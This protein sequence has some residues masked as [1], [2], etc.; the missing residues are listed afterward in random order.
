MFRVKKCMPGAAVWSPE[1][2]H[3]CANFSNVSELLDANLSLEVTANLTLLCNF[4]EQLLQDGAWDAANAPSGFLPL[5]NSSSN[6][7]NSTSGGSAASSPRAV[8]EILSALQEQT[9]AMLPAPGPPPRSS[10]VCWELH[11]ENQTVILKSP[12][13]CER[14]CWKNNIV[15]AYGKCSARNL[16]VNA[17]VDL[18]RPVLDYLA[19]L[20][21]ESFPTTNNY[22]RERFVNA[23]ALFDLMNPGVWMRTADGPAIFELAGV[24][25]LRNYLEQWYRDFVYPTELGLSPS[26]SSS[27]VVGRMA[28]HVVASLTKT[29]YVHAHPGFVGVYPENLREV[30]YKQPITPLLF[31][32]GRVGWPKTN[33]SAFY[34]P[35]LFRVPS[36]DACYVPDDSEKRADVSYSIAVF[37]REND[38]V[39]ED[40]VRL[41]T[42]GYESC[43][44]ETFAGL[45]LEG[46]ALGPGVVVRI[47][48]GVFTDTTRV[49]EVDGREPVR[50]QAG[51]PAGDHRPTGSK[52]G[53][54][55][56]VD[57]NVVLPDASLTPFA[58]RELPHFNRSA[59]HVDG[60][61]VGR[62]FDDIRSVGSLPTTPGVYSDATLFGQFAVILRP[63]D[64]YREAWEIAIRPGG[65]RV[66]AP[67]SML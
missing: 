55:I 46:S 17:F 60:Y 25:G 30:L 8:T 19:W 11:G 40:Y 26:A 22:T 65:R 51:A 56:D 7:S 12:D 4:T 2:D 1:V 35:E 14:R 53:L 5:L 31:G 54:V 45:E 16:R 23:S 62:H 41:V 36:S 21:D 38:A 39:Y 29:T 27:A 10:E 15:R 49:P 66:F 9:A 43:L 44:S 42:T 24:E 34:T 67:S 59:H 64:Q 37:D 32:D 48:G 58:D 33:H 6:S 47:V 28:P 50:E 18:N 20:A 3:Y 57:G 52:N 13:R 63:W 61:L